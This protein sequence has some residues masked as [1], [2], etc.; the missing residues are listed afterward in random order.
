MP[1]ALL[2]FNYFSIPLFLGIIFAII[3]VVYISKV[4][5]TLNYRVL[6]IFSIATI[7]WLSTNSVELLINSQQQKILWNHL[8]FIGICIVPVSFF[9]FVMQYAGYKAW[10]KP[11]NVA[12]ISVLPFIYTIT[13]FTNNFHHL[14]VVRYSI[15]FDGAN[16]YL[17]KEYGAFFWIWTV[18]AYILIAISFYQLFKMLIVSVK[19]YKFTTIL[20]MMAAILPIAANIVYLAG[21]FPL[22]HID[23]TPLLLSISII[24]LLIGVI[25]L[26]LGN[27][28]PVT[29]NA[30]LENMKDGVIV[31][32]KRNYILEINP[33]AY[34]LI[35]PKNKNI[36]GKN[37]KDIWPKSI[38]YL[39]EPGRGSY[40]KIQITR[41][42]AVSFYEINVNRN[43]NHYKQLNCTTIIL[44]DITEKEKSE[45]ILK[46]KARFAKLVARV[47]ASFMSTPPVNINKKIDKALRIVGKFANADRSYVFL[48]TKD[49]KYMDNTN[50]WA[51]EGIEPQKNNCR[52]LPC[53]Q[54]KLLLDRLVACEDVYIEDV[55]KMPPEADYI[56]GVLKAQDIQSIVLV[57]MLYKNHLQGFLG[58][59]SVKSRKKWNDED[60]SL[61]RIMGNIFINAI[62]NYKADRKIKYL[63][64]YDSLT[65]LYN[66]AYFEEEL[67]RL[68]TKRQLPLSII[69]GDINGLKLAND[70]FGH[71]E[72]DRLLKTSSAVL[73][74]CCRED[75]IVARWGGDEFAILLPR[76]PEKETKEIMD[77]IK[78]AVNKTNNKKVP[79][80]ISL[81]TA[82]KTVSGT[83][84]LKVIKK[85]ED[86]MYR[87]KLLERKSMFSSLLSSLERSL[88][89]KSHET[90]D[91]AK[92]LQELAIKL[93][94]AIKLP[95]SSMDDLVLLAKLHD[96]GKIAIPEKI[97]QKKNNLNNE[98][99]DIMKRHSEIGHNIVFASP[100]LAHIG[101]AILCHHERWDGM[102]YPHRLS[103]D[104]IPVTSRIISIVDAYDV[105]TNDRPYKRAY[106][107]N[108]A[109]KELEN[110]SGKQFDPKLVEIFL[111]I[112]N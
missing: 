97:L 72:G 105:M 10:S 70:A 80:S 100:Q 73:R 59:D 75:D 24:I 85:A 17:V 99:W 29:K 4:K 40:E 21:L 27:V 11:R 87:R 64:F 51:A 111:K 95:E 9:V 60:L 19:F 37:I 26:N 88:W 48:I 84:I 55:D 23:F 1:G 2:Q 3:F 107:K 65:G 62:E 6:I 74:K 106:T 103:G 42:E 81:G 43:F 38:E 36:I 20:L 52:M 101:E 93:G 83:D 110:L 96:I 104:Q 5:P 78:N 57:P 46:Y 69:I 56:A 45:K 66:R 79:L 92:R 58:F 63:S 15:L 35:N 14:V 102:G 31:L 54:F 108:E 98:E 16:K 12:A 18:Y 67:K 90:Q 91:H 41:N 94:N 50:E 47:S 39:N 32:D 53:A 8:S 33:I 22:S 77:R 71:M 13:D 82:T 61:L 76:T 7:L 86:L 68:N 44:R 25:R 34:E 49:F 109:K 30:I 112:L 28:I 89:E